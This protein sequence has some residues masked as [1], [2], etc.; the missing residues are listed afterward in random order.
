MKNE[1]DTVITEE[2]IFH[3]YDQLNVDISMA[4]DIGQLG[5]EYKDAYVALEK[6]DYTTFAFIGELLG[7]D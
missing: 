2:E 4:L 6:D 3:F 7:D 1:L 5:K